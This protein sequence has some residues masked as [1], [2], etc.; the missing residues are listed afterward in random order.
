MLLVTLMRCV[1][2]GPPGVSD[3]PLA[4]DRRSCMNFGTA[5]YTHVKPV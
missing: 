2:G 1:T 3:V 5:A 4:G